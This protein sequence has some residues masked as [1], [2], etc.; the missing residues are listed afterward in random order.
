MQNQI[1]LTQ[2]ELTKREAAARQQGFEEGRK[3]EQRL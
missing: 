2:E 3:Y 1:T